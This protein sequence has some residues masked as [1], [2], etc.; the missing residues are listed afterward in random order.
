M[1]LSGCGFWQY[2]SSYEYSIGFLGEKTLQWNGRKE[3]FL[4]FSVFL[5]FE[6]LTF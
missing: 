4:V 2:G 3:E 1:Q 6:P 5:F